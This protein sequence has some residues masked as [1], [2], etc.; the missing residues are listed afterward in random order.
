MK[1][2]AGTVTYVGD[3]FKGARAVSREVSDKD[4]LSAFMW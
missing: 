2:V 3:E 4:L 1:I